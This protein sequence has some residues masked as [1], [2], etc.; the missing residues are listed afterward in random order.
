MA[1]STS[2]W[3]LGYIFTTHVRIVKVVVNAKDLL[4]VKTNGGPEEDQFVVV[5]H[6][7]RLFILTDVWFL[8]QRFDIQSLLFIRRKI[9]ANATTFLQ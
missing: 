2:R 1:G 6:C 7:H 3:S 4:V 5:P 9:R 8:P